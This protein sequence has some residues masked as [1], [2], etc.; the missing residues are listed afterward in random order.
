LPVAAP[1]ES[2]IVFK[3]GGAATVHCLPVVPVLPVLPALPF[4]NRITDIR[5]FLSAS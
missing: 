5:D 1:R 3:A 4:T 2:F